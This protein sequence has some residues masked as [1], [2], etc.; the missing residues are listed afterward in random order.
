VLNNR[1]PRQSSSR[2]VTPVAAAAA[3]QAVAV[4]PD[5]RV[6]SMPLASSHIISNSSVL[7]TSFA[8]YE[9][10]VESFIHWCKRNDL[11]LTDAA[12]VDQHLTTFMESL[13]V[14]SMPNCKNLANN[15]LF[16]M[17]R[18]HPE[19]KTQLPRARLA[20][21]GIEKLVPSVQRVPI[22]W[23]ACVAI[24]S[25]MAQSGYIYRAVAVLLMFH[26]LLRIGEAASITVG[27]VVS[28]RRLQGDLGDSAPLMYA[29]VRIAEAKTGVEQSVTITDAHIYH[30]VCRISADRHASEKLFDCSDSTLGKTFATAVRSLGLGH[31]ENL[32]PHSCRH[33]GATYAHD[34]GMRI[35]DILVRGR[36]AVN[37]SAVHYMQ[38][39]RGAQIAIALPQVV[40]DIGLWCMG[41]LSERLYSMYDEYMAAQQAQ[42]LPPPPPAPTAA[43]RRRGA[44]SASKKKGSGKK[45]KRNRRRSPS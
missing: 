9:R 27:D 33:G 8:D 23:P 10:A 40:H 6:V 26:C 13:F 2:R 43:R 25:V 15:A 29:I 11:L 41:N 28:P 32:T 4:Q 7:P 45:R 5:E 31:I 12:C 1:R 21:K 44:G 3:L 34:R 20:R 36:W 19:L 22:P 24:A 35:E 18:R 14:N 37:K 42:Q 16:G 17:I 39:L 38:T 30:L